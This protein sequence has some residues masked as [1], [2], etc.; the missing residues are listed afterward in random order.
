MLNREICVLGGTGFLGSR[1]VSSLAGSGYTVRVASRNAANHRHL[2]VLPTVSARTCDIQNP[3]ALRSLVAGSSVVVNLVGILNEKDRKGA[4]FRKAH[5]DLCAKLVDACR[6]GQV[7]RLVQVS[8]LKASASNGPSHY[9]RTKGEAEDIIKAQSG[10]L[11]WTILQPSVIFGPG[12]AFINRFAELLRRIP[13]VFPLAKP[14]A[15]FAPVH[16]DDVV[17][18]IRRVMHDKASNGVTY[19]VYGAEVYSLREI[20]QRISRATELHR[21]VLGLPDWLARAQARLM[22]FLPG[23]PFSM[24]NYRSLSVPSVGTDDGLANLGIEPRSFDL[25]VDSCI[26]Q[27]RSR[28]PHDIHRRSAGR[29]TG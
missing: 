29:Q 1:L 21:Y 5:T 13:G 15:L 16:V 18:A 26:D 19:Q 14:N 7:A 25:N 24:D 22:E 27:I 10:E 9:L 20:V 4:G 12:D 28:T 11:S 17:L 3:D 2:K 8:A 23:K 6:Q